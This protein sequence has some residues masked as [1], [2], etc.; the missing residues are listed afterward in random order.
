MIAGIIDW[1]GRNRF[2]VI[3]ASLALAL[4]GVWAAL[5]SPLDAI[6][7]LSDPQVIVFAEW[8]GRSPEL[9]ESQVTY[10]L[11]TGLQALPGV[12]A[13]RGFTMF[14]MSFTYVLL[15]DGVDPYW[16][17]SRVSERLQQLESRLPPEAELSLGPDASAVGWIYQYVLVDRSG[18]L[19]AADLR[20]LQDWTLRFELESVAG[21]A[22]VASLG[23]FEKQYQVVLDPERLR[24]AGILPGDGSE[25]GR[26]IHLL[27]GDA[28]VN[29]GKYLRA[30]KNE[31]FEFIQ[32][33]RGGYRRA[34]PR[35]QRRLS[36][37]DT[38]HCSRTL[39]ACG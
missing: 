26:L 23:G 1:S 17:R 24:A 20:S 13:V 16:A 8:M 15:E 29:A 31:V 35:Q 3:V 38:R 33:Y 9:V 21:V 10:P 36:S 25:H 32:R 27:N 5:R 6:P 11:V 28:K 7:D 12:R 34:R 19:S 30:M 18:K 2:F 39:A 4:A 37:L 14:G 22:E